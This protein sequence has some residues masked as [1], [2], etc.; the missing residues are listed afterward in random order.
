MEAFMHMADKK[1]GEIP[2]LSHS[3][4]ADF[5]KKHVIVGWEQW[6]DFEFEW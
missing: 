2:I 1:Q 4:N 6:S 5:T 3:F